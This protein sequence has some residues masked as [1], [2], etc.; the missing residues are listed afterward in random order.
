VKVTSFLFLDVVLYLAMLG[1]T[2]DLVQGNRTP[3]TRSH[4]YN[5]FA[6]AVFSFGRKCG[7]ATLWDLRQTGSG[8]FVSDVRWH[9]LQHQLSSEED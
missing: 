1:R 6:N 7:E 9:A 2:Q 3:D 8:Y 5:E 4:H